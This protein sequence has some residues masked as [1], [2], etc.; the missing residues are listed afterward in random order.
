MWKK[1]ICVKSLY[2][3]KIWINAPSEFQMVLVFKDMQP[4]WTTGL[5]K[6]ILYFE[7]TPGNEILWNHGWS[8]RRVHSPQEFP[9][10]FCSILVP[11]SPLGKQR[12]EWGEAPSGCSCS[13]FFW[14]FLWM[15]GVQQCGSYHRIGK[16]ATIVAF[17][18]WEGN[19]KKAGGTEATE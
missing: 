7:K 17:F 2:L 14:R 8:R 4:C 10:S 12:R 1:V 5:I 6:L 13:G 16:L 11:G 19:G 18:I 15:R 3:R 9:N